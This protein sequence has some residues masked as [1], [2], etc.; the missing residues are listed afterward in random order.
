MLDITH[1]C[2]VERSVGIVGNA[3]FEAIVWRKQHVL[4]VSDACAVNNEAILERLGGIIG[5]RYRPNAIGILRHW[6]ALRQNLTFKF[7]LLGIGRLHSEDDA[8]LR[9]LWRENRFGEESCHYTGCK[10]LFLSCLG[11][12]RLSVL[13]G[14]RRSL[15][16]EQQR[17]RTCQEIFSIH[18]RMTELTRGGFLHTANS[19]LVKELHIVAG[20]A[21]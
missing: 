15:F 19:L 16:V 14:Q 7:Y 12:S 6:Q 3:V 10:L 8:I 17:Q 20:V 11:R 4:R 13:H 2:Q 1:Q 18:P 9:I 5:H 21:I